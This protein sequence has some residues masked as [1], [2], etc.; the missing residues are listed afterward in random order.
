M[1][2]KINKQENKKIKKKREDCWDWCITGP[3]IKAR[4]TQTEMLV[5]K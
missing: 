3:V 1:N 2:K 4:T 5:K